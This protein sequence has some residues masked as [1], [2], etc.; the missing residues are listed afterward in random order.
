MK[1]INVAIVGCGNISDIYLHNLTKI[2]KN[3]NVYAV[4]DLI[5]ENRKEKAE[6]YSVER[7]MTFEQIIAD[8]QIDMVLNITTPPVHFDICREALLAGKHVYVEKP[9]SLTFEQ[10]EELVKIA[11][12][13]D[14]LLGCAPDTF[15][16]AGIQTCR[17]II[18][19]GLIGDVIGATAFM[20][21]HGHESWHPN[22]EFYYKKG[23][24]P[25]FDM[26]PYYLTALVNLVGNVK[27]VSGM[28]AISQPTRTITSQ[29]KYG[30]IIDVEVPTHVNGLL[31]FENGAIGNII[32][33]F[34]V[35]GSVLPRIEVYGTHGALMVPDPNTF[36][37][38][39]LLKQ[40]FDGEFRK[41]PLITPYSNN[42]RGIGLADMANCVLEGRTD[43]RASGDL[44]LHVL[45]IMQAIHTSSDTHCEVELT[46]KCAKPAPC[47]KTADIER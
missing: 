37:G 47:L 5:E 25:M 35:W 23:G 27:S 3:V 38:E 4:S 30:Q 29:P 20:V 41:Y 34:D 13:Q 17:K 7:I 31:R 18:D 28:T 46:T 6:K 43:H 24:G 10:G 12:E 32:T 44:A 42:C 33:S 11:K 16:G 36:D 19:D 9:L 39:V 8:E 1:K 14:V 22:P 45:E 2:F 26:G 15:M 40:S 21:C